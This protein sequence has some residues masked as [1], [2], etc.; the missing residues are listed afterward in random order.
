MHLVI[1][2]SFIAVLAKLLSD[3]SLS[4]FS[5]TITLLCNLLRLLMALQVTS[6]QYTVTFYGC[7]KDNFLFFFSLIFAQNIY[8]GY[9]YINEVILTATLSMY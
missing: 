6:M 1:S 7:K 2:M 9:V 3:V 8:I 4:R 5:I